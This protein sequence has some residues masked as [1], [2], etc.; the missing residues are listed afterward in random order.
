MEVELFNKH[1]D[2]VKIAVIGVGG[3]GIH[4]LRN[5]CNINY[6]LLALDTP[7]IHVTAYDGD[8]VSEANVAR[9]LFSPSDIG[10][11]KAVT[12]IWRINRYYGYS[13][14]AVNER[15]STSNVEKFDIV[16]SCV[17][18]L[19]S[20]IVVEQIFIKN[21]LQ[22]K[23]ENYWIDTGNDKNSGQVVLGSRNTET[24]IKTVIEEYGGNMSDIEHLPSC[25]TMQSLVRQDLFVNQRIAL[26]ATN[27]I[28][29]EMIREKKLT[30]ARIFIKNRQTTSIN[31]S[32]LE[33]NF[34]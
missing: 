20:R 7:G 16:I 18:S 31:V 29:T 12:M 30:T 17:D 15:A 1:Y 4:V 5:L 11:N 26:E 2:P 27:L 8:D 13:W 24:E 25:S 14:K 34:A 9:Q 6:A 19:K 3:T 10:L 22:N 23:S 33:K 21:S 32:S 28:W